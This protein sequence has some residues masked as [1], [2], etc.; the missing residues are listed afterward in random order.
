MLGHP[1]SL[2]GDIVRF[3]VFV[4]CLKIADLICSAI[5]LV[6]ER[7]TQLL[8][9]W[10]GVTPSFDKYC[11]FPMFSL[12]AQSSDIILSFGPLSFLVYIH[13][14]Q[15]VGLK[16]GP[17]IRH[18]NLKTKTVTMISTMCKDSRRFTY[19]IHLGITHVSFYRYY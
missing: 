2:E 11:N 12:L 19:F 13:F 14:W 17:K 6:V 16:Y 10:Q 4:E 7:H 9:L 18:F 8:N 5:F 15:L 3:Y 1:R